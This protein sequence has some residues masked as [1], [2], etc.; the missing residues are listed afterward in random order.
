MANPEHVERLKENTSAWNN[1]RQDLPDTKPDLSGADLR[2]LS[3][4]GTNLSYA[5]LCNAALRWTQLVDVDL[6]RAQLI[7][8]DF[9]WA[10]LRGVKLCKA[11]LARAR[12]DGTVIVRSNFDGANLNGAFSMRLRSGSCRG[13]DYPECPHDRGERVK[14]TS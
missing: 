14:P 2:D 8:T 1:W 13:P 11:N 6:R 10:D 4:K 3:F 7:E 9:R 5:N 12:F